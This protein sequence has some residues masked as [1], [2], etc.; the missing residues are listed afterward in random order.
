MS[1]ELLY[2]SNGETKENSVIVAARKSLKKH[3]D[4]NLPPVKKA[5]H[6]RVCRGCGKSGIPM[7]QKWINKIG[8]QRWLCEECIPRKEEFDY[9]VGFGVLSRINKVEDNK[10]QV[11]AA[12]GI[13]HDS[14]K[15]QMNLLPWDVLEKVAEVLDIGARKYSPDNWRVVPNAVKRYEDAL[16]RHF[17]AY[18]KG[19][20]LDPEDGLSHLAHM[21]C[22]A[23]FLVAFR[24]EGKV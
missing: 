8:Q 21:A 15:L 2:P 19:E 16:L 18:K 11:R 4:E 20:D 10:A 22:N 1:K 17:A 6:V 23:L 14:G 5:R 3:D 7:K 24:E 12:S 13:K 9:V